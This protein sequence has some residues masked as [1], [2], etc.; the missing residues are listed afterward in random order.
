MTVIRSTKIIYGTN[1]YR[2]EKMIFR[3]NITKQFLL[4]CIIL[5]SMV[6]LGH[7]GYISP[8][9]ICA[10]PDGSTLYVAELTAGKV[11]LFDTASQ[12]VTHEITLPAPNQASGVGVEGNFCKFWFIFL[13][14]SKN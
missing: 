5:T 2:N 7:A 4:L 1:I 12:A 13:K 3:I 8:V 6:S 11:A 14:N 10:S 9:D